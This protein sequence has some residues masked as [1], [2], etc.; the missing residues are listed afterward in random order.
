MTANIETL[1]ALLDECEAHVATNEEAAAWLAARGVT[2]EEAAGSAPQRSLAHL[3]WECR[4]VAKRGGQC[5]IWWEDLL[6]LC[7]AVDDAGRAARA[8]GAP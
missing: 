1:A 5:F 3:V 4:E 6:R 7:D 8:A 2:V